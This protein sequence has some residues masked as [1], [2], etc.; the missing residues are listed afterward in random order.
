[1]SNRALIIRLNAACLTAY[2]ILP[3]VDKNWNHVCDM[4]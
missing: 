4:L 2:T 3:L 1:M